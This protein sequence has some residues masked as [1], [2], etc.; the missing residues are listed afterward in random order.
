[1]C[2]SSSGCSVLVVLFCSLA[3]F[4]C[5]SCIGSLCSCSSP[6]SV[7]LYSWVLGCVSCMRLCLVSVVCRMSVLWCPFY[8]CVCC[9]WCLYLW[10]VRV[11]YVLA[12]LL[13]LC[14]V[15]L[16]RCL[17]VFCLLPVVCCLLSIAC[18]RCCSIS[19]VLCLLL[20]DWLV[21]LL[22]VGVFVVGGVLACMC[23]VLWC[24]PGCFCVLGLCFWCLFWGGWVGWGVLGGGVPCF[25]RGAVFQGF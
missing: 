25:L 3:C 8:L 14:F 6:V 19:S 12:V 15:V 17:V 1:M 22:C 11:C 7:C 10:L 23:V 5:V 13:W 2:V 18:C 20:A 21:V 9:V 16:F 4:L 24:C